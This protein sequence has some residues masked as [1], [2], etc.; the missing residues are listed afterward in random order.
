MTSSSSTSSSPAASSLGEF[1]K[2]LPT[3]NRENFSNVS[4]GGSYDISSAQRQH[5]N[6]STG[7][8]CR[9]RNPLYV[10]TKDFPGEQRIVT[11]KTNIL[12]RYLHQ[13]W[14]KKAAQQQQ[15][16]R[17]REAASEA[18]EVAGEQRKKARLETRLD[19]AGNRSAS[20]SMASGTAARRDPRSGGSEVNGIFPGAGAV[21]SSTS[22]VSYSLQR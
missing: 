6:S 19:S 20:S 21:T 14:D 10:P 8:S 16:H 12:L 7:V 5:Y 4:L 18:C 1:L 15:L 9:Y 2:N 22:S 11:E 3:H 17:K 13:Q